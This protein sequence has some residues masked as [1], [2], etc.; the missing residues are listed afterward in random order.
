MPKSDDVADYGPDVDADGVPFCCT[1]CPHAEEWRAWCTLL[2]ESY[3]A[4]G[5]AARRCPPP[6]CPARAKELVN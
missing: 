4:L 3:E 2:D 5:R 1:V 6:E